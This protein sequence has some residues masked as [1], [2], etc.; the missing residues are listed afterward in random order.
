[1]EQNKTD[2]HVNISGLFWRI[3]M[4]DLLSSLIFF[5]IVT[6]GST[7]L[8]AFAYRN[9]KFVLKHKIAVKREEAVTR[10][11]GKKLSEDKKMSK[12]EKDER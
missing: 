3:H 12:K 1:M 2:S 8:V 7:Y 4:I 9:T 10:E 5:I 11:M 6:M